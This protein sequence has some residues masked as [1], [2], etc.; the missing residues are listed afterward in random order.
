M[1]SYHMLSN[2]I[3][4]DA[5]M[6]AASFLNVLQHL[7]YYRSVTKE[8]CLQNVAFCAIVNIQPNHLVTFQDKL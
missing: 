8:T 4:L 2:S 3:D 7:N 6:L 1:T 5:K